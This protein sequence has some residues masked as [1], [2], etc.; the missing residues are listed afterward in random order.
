MKN[1]TDNNNIWRVVI[2]I[3]RKK[4]AITFVKTIQEIH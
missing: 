4:N 2:Q 3:P 1:V